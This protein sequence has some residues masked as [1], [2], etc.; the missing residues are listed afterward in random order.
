MKTTANQPRIRV[1]LIEDDED[2]FFITRDLL[3][4]V[5]DLSYDLI[6]QR[7]YDAGLTTLLQGDIDVCLMDFQLGARNGLELFQE[8]VL[9]QRSIPVILLTG[10]D[11]KEI[12][13]RAM[14]AGASDFLVKGRIDAPLLDRSIRYAIRHKKSEERMQMMAYYDPLTGLP[15]RA[16]FR[17]RLEQAIASAERYDRQLALMFLDLDNFKRINDTLGHST[18]DALLQ[19]VACRLQGCL[20]SCDAMTRGYP[21]LPKSMVAR[22][23]GDEFTILLTELAHPNNTI[24]L[25]ERILEALSRPIQQG[26][27]E[28]FVTVSIGITLFPHDGQDLETLLKQ[29]DTAMYHAKSQGRNNYQYYSEA[30]NSKAVARLTIESRL[31]K[32]I[33]RNELDLYY[34]PQINVLTGQIVGLEAL[35]RWN[36]PELGV[37]SPADFIPAAEETGLITP[38]GEW[39]IHRACQQLKSWHQAGLHS[40]RMAVNVSRLQFRRNALLTQ[41]ARALETSRLDPRNLELEITEGVLLQDTDLHSQ[42]LNQLKAMGFRL[43][44]DDFGTG[45]SSLSMLKRFPFDVIKIDRSFIQDLTEDSEEAGIVQA[46]VTMT[47]CLKR[48]VI[49]EGVE[50]AA[51]LRLLAAFGCIE[52]Q[53]HYFSRPLPAQTLTPLLLDKTGRIGSMINQ[54][55]LGKASAEDPSLASL[56]QSSSPRVTH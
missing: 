10:M 52:M 2:D 13:V 48:S 50:T 42:Q 45:F 3:S 8:P 7:T 43:V 6:W 27:I 30:M 32:A 54:A 35:L 21:E 47:R 55:L 19:E 46:I 39:V 34:Q 12:D 36:S 44:L 22:L 17:D 28:F 51:Q 33:D 29:A 40:L 20:R 31:H 38:I 5:E 9:R 18:G 16:L 37:V 49:A 4:E 1:L 41:V 11:D 23:G 14:T 56:R 24:T 15:N 26:S 25:A 53:G